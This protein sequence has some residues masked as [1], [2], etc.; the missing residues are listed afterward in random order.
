METIPQSPFLSLTTAL[1]DAI[2][3]LNQQNIYPNKDALHS[4][5]QKKY[6]EIVTP[7]LKL[8]HDCLSR[9]IRERRLY[10][11]GRGYFVLKDENFL[12]EVMTSSKNAEKISSNSNTST[13]TELD[14]SH[15]DCARPKSHTNNISLK[16]NSK[17]NNL[18][19]SVDEKNSSV[20]IMK[21]LTRN[22]KLQNKKNESKN[23]ITENN[24]HIQS[25][26]K[27]NI[28]SNYGVTSELEETSNLSDNEIKIEYTQVKRSNS[29]HG[30]DSEKSF[31]KG[32]SFAIVGCKNEK[33]VSNFKRHYSFG[34][35]SQNVPRLPQMGYNNR[36]LVSKTISSFNTI[37]RNDF[38]EQK[39]R[40]YEKRYT[41][42]LD[43]KLD[44]KVPFQSI[45][46]RDTYKE[47]LYDDLGSALSITNHPITDMFLT[48]KFHPSYKELSL[49][50]EMQ[51][52]EDNKIDLH[53]EKTQ[54]IIHN[55]ERLAPYRKKDAALNNL[56]ISFTANPNLPQQNLDISDVSQSLK[57]KSNG[58][59]YAP[60]ADSNLTKSDTNANQAVSFNLN[61]ERKRNQKERNSLLFAEKRGTLRVVGFV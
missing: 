40:H 31:K 46:T 34:A 20:S 56:E 35:G 41:D 1:F 55:V 38:E 57:K 28:T 36:V 61:D 15:K 4:Y 9:L 33:D 43:E 51:I 45:V 23:Q 37:K 26:I 21:F 17:K 44:E 50:D 30:T 14:A 18:T 32:V 60:F 48:K 2:A 10:H 29:F 19:L 24:S 3:D 49:A 5:L 13:Q 16:K 53:Q 7:D 52:A 27:S 12:N 42:V 39:V 22:D 8:I 59:L 58:Y 6:S 11:N 25:S 54:Q 47:N